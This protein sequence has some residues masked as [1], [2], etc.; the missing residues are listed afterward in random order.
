MDR[1]RAAV[2]ETRRRIVEATLA[3][4]IE[5]GMFDTSWRDIAE[6]ADV[7][8]ATVYKHFPTMDELVPACGALIMSI[9]DPPSL[10]DAP[11]IFGGART[12]EER[13]GRLVS[14]LYGF[15]ERGEP[16]IEVGPKERELQAVREWEAGMRVV[17]EGLAREAL[18]TERPEDS[19]VRAVGAL[20]DFPVYKSF[21]RNGIARK[22]A[23]ETVKGMLLCWI[24]GRRSGR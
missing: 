2:E 8:V 12:V 22:G 7:S 21:R 19:T 14:E 4:H 13:V 23:E 5:K 16:Y 11:R 24:R 18:R 9:T 10:E 17:R 1:R 15:Y 3:L 6:R 20:L